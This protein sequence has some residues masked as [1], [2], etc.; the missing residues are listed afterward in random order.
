MMPV[1]QGRNNFFYCSPHLLIFFLTLSDL[2][3]LFL[4][5]ELFFHF[6][7]IFHP[8]NKNNNIKQQLREGRNKWRNI[9]KSA[10]ISPQIKTRCAQCAIDV[11]LLRIEHYSMFLRAE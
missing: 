3:F 1:A 9:K 2:F 5:A 11:D 10:I 4:Y 7:C 6:I 8:F